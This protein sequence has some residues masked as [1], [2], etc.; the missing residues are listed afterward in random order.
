MPLH[1]G[2]YATKKKFWRWIRV[3]PEILIKLQKGKKY[4]ES[5]YEMKFENAIAISALVDEV[6]SLA[7]RI[8]S[9]EET[10]Q[11][12]QKTNREYL[13]KLYPTK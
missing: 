7:N 3:S 9:Q 1:L 6:C 11:L 4:L 2:D 5:K 10:I 13:E 8:K 12:L